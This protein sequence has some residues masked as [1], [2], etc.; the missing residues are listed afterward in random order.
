MQWPGTKA[1]LPHC[2][3]FHYHSPRLGEGIRKIPAQSKI[4]I[5][6]IGTAKKCVM[7]FVRKLHHIS[8]ASR[9]EMEK[10]FG[11]DIS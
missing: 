2:S 6:P 1:T 10:A 8:L 11:M 9:C 7:G 3:E 5:R 4:Y